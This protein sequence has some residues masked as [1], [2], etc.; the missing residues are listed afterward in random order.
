MFLWER[1]LQRKAFKDQFAQGLS[2]VRSR[3]GNAIISFRAIT[4]IIIYVTSAKG[5][6]AM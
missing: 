6:L 3:F 1:L 5:R 4:I 2:K